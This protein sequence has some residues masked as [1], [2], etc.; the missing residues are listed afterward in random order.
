MVSHSW[1]QLSSGVGKLNYSGSHFFPD[2]GAEGSHIVIDCVASD[3][4]LL[5]DCNTCPEEIVGT[6]RNEKRSADRSV[7]RILPT[8]NSFTETL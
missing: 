8:T 6:V 4:A 1:R 7:L 3:H 5:R 2:H